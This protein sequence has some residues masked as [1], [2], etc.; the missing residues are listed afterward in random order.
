MMFVSA[1]IA[2]IICAFEWMAVIVFLIEESSDELAGAR[3][4]D[5]LAGAV[6][7]SIFIDIYDVMQYIECSGKDP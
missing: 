1:W 2:A 5:S 6:S 7:N 4:T 3:C